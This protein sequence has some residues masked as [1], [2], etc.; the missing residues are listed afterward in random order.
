MGP[1]AN[2]TTAL[3]AWLLQSQAGLWS[4]LVSNKILERE[5]RNHCGCEMP[6]LFSEDSGK[7]ALLPPLLGQALTLG[8]Q[9][10][11]FLLSNFR[12]PWGSP[13][14]LQRPCKCPRFFFA[15]SWRGCPSP[16]FSRPQLRGHLACLSPRSP[17][18]GLRALRR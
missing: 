7:E 14:E 2:G 10:L 11:F 9:L 3:C 13:L 8:S 15:A 1:K 18:P 16:C 5:A 17:P 4:C 12:Y 6:S